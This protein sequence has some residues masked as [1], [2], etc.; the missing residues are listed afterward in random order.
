MRCALVPKNGNAGTDLVFSGFCLRFGKSEHRGKKLFLDWVHEGSLAG[1]LGYR[2][3]A[4]EL[5]CGADFSLKWMCGAGPSDLGR[6]RG[7][8]SA[9]N[10]RKTGPK[11]SSQTAFRYPV[12]KLVDKLGVGIGGCGAS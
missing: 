4:L 2:E 3:M 7:P 5:V 11:I 9:E 1:F 8:V 12:V 10:P 6:S